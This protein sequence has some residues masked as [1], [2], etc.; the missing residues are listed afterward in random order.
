MD[1]IKILGGWG[2]SNPSLHEMALVSGIPGK[3]GVDGQQVAD[4]WLKG[5][6]DR[7]I[8]YNE[9]DALTTYLLW[10]RVGHFS[11]H[12][13]DKEYDEEQDRVRE[14]LRLEGAKP[15]RSH[16]RDFLDMWESLRKAVASGRNGHNTTM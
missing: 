2:K 4:L 5:E 13:T 11:G 10:L 16:L 15:G 8:A 14:L 7:I 9:C 12:L 3:M 6:L 1:L